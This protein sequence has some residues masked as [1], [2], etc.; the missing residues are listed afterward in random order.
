MKKRLMI[1]L[2]ALF[3]LV[4][5]LGVLSA[6]GG[7]ADGE[8]TISETE[9]TLAIG[10]TTRLMATAKSGEE[11][12][13]TSSDENVVVIEQ[14]IAAR[15]IAVIKAAGAGKATVTA[16]S[17]S[18][19]KVSCE[20]TVENITVE[21]SGEGVAD[22]KLQMERNTSLKLNAVVKKDGAVLGDTVDWASSDSSIVTVAEDGTLEAVMTGTATVTATRHGGGSRSEIEVTVIWS[23]QPQG[24]YTLEAWEQNKITPNLWGY[25]ADAGYEPQYSTNIKVTNAE[26]LGDPTGTG[27]VAGGVTLSYENQTTGANEHGVQL[28]YRSSKGYNDA[29]KDKEGF[30]PYDA[31]KLLL[32]VNGYY[33][34]KMDITV[35]ASGTITVNGTQIDVVANEKQS[36]EVPFRHTDTG[37]I[38]PSGEYDNVGSAVYVMMGANG[39]MI[40]KA[41]VTLENISW[42]KSWDG[43][44]STLQPPTFTLSGN[45]ITIT[46]PNKEG[47]KNYTV[48]IFSENAADGA[49]PVRTMTVAAGAKEVQIDDAKWPNGKYELRIRANG[50]DARYVTSAWSQGTPYTVSHGAVSYDL[51]EGLSGDAK[52]DTTDTYYYSVSDDA[53][54]E[55]ATYNDG[56][57]TLTYKG[58]TNWYSVQLFYKNPALTAGVK[59]TL[60]FTL[61]SPLAGKIRIN[62]TMFDLTVGDN[63]IAVSYTEGSGADGLSMSIQFGEPDPDSDYQSTVSV[64]SEGTFTLKDIVWERYVAPEGSIP[65]GSQ[66]DAVKSPGTWYLW[67]DQGWNDETVTMK[68]SSIDEEKKTIF[69]SYTA[70]GANKYGAGVQLF[71]E[72]PGVTEGSPYV[73]TLTIKVSV[74]CDI[75]VCGQVEHFTANTARPLTITQ[76]EP[77]YGGENNEGATI[78]I[79]MG[80]ENPLSN[81]PAADVTVSDWSVQAAAEEELTFGEDILPSQNAMVNS[82]KNDAAHALDTFMYWYVQDASWNC[83]SVVTMNTTTYENNTVTLGYQGGDQ[84]YSVQLF[85]ANSKLIAGKRYKISAA[86]TATKDMTI[87]V[88]NKQI[89]LKANEMANIE[90]VFTLAT[91]ALEDK[92]PWAADIQFPGMTDTVT[93][94]ISGLKWNEV[95]SK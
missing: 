95:I 94:T 14:Q 74:D 90:Y 85:Y 80:V 45:T 83:G 39:T 66:A 77:G 9:V 72:H 88:N 87:K 38:Y 60:T 8:M 47:V 81:V 76:N 32:D 78:V 89:S 48:G 82:G 24:W 58:N 22:G 19:K 71:Y 30:T 4:L 11:V 7:G 73:I 42:D 50:K 75:R 18:G 15:G 31:N 1:A 23:N 36:I 67:W 49:D 13:W 56:T 10:E 41:T 64:L 91:N 12:G 70:T 61:N 52:A 84:D 3:A 59:Y 92:A 40:Q 21:I 28:F 46:D 34:L 25:W 54:M 27:L 53:V 93:V 16:E 63:P 44:T 51:K 68:E 69:F 20:V 57:I 29:N 55:T 33:V 6:C 5:G 17:A 65:E 86:V 37:Y 79:I 43:T 26:Y 2:T 35:T 62:G